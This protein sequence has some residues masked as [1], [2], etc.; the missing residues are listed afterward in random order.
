MLPLVV[1]LMRWMPIAPE[2]IA[3]EPI[4]PKKKALN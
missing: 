3:P 1:T 4:A 2:P